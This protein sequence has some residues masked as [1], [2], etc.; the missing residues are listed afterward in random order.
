MTTLRYVAYYE[1]PKNFLLGEVPLTSLSFPKKT[2]FN[3]PVSD[4]GDAYL[5]K[6]I[7]GA[8]DAYYKKRIQ[9]Q[10]IQNKNYPEKGEYW[11]IDRKSVFKNLNDAKTKFFDDIFSGRSK[12]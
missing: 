7:L 10:I 12:K 3:G 5:S 2:K 8:G 1:D 9:V 4:I 11:A 6:I